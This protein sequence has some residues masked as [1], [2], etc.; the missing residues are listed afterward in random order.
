[1]TGVFTP[2]RQAGFTCVYKCQNFSFV[3]TTATI[4]TSITATAISVSFKLR[5]FP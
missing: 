4:T 5:V 3:L 1:M 2:G